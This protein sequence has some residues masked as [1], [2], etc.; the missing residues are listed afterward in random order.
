MHVY[1]VCFSDG[2]YRLSTFEGIL[3]TLK[4]EAQVIERQVLEGVGT[5]DGVSI[6]QVRARALN[7]AKKSHLNV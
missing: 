6:C 1:V 2:S 7:E 3:L 4:R 5:V